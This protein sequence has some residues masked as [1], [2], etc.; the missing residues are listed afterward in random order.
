MPEI[1]VLP[2]SVWSAGLGGAAA[3]MIGYAGSVF[4]NPAGIAPIRILSLEGTGARYDSVS[5]FFSGATAFRA[6]RTN[7]GA[8]LRYLS[9]DDGQPLRD[10]VEGQAAFSLRLK[11]VAWGLGA[12]Y[13]SVEDS[14]GE[15]SRALTAGGAGRRPGSPYSPG[16]L[17]GSLVLGRAALDYAYLARHEHAP[18]HLFG[19]RWTPEADSR[20]HPGT[21][22]RSLRQ[23]RH[24]VARERRGEISDARRRGAGADPGAGA[25]AR[26]GDRRSG[27]RRGDARP[28]QLV[29]EVRVFAD[30]LGFAAGDTYTTYSDVGRDT[31]LLVVSASFAAASAPTPG[32]IPIVGKVPYKGFFDPRMA[33][34]EAARLETRG[35]DIYLRPSGAYATLG[36]FKDPLLS[37]ALTRDSMELAATVFHEMAHN[38]LYVKSATAFNESFAQYAG[39]PCGGAVLHRAG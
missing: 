37:T 6:G 17:G 39:L 3:A 5:T 23:L 13:V 25:T 18:L 8:G 2:P 32:S 26:A 10:N 15:V 36:W 11:G 34:A 33:H 16:T 22:G 31:L 9:Y 30:S 1:F 27:H 21:G 28:A 29:M 38:T 4:A 7:I 14:A 24:R 12:G 35:L 20:G 19:L